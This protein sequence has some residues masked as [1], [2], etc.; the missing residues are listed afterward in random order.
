M[1]KVTKIIHHM[2]GFQNGLAL[3]KMDKTWYES[4]ENS[5]RFLKSLY[6]ARAPS[7]AW[8]AAM[9]VQKKVFA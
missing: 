1:N 3:Q 2:S 6:G 9:Q 4:G 7:V 5:V 8:P